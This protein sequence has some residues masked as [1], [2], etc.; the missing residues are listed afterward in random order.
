MWAVDSCQP[1]NSELS[2]MYCLCSWR[3]GRSP[4]EGNGNTLQCSHLEN[5]MDGGAWWATV[6]EVAKSWTIEQITL[7][8]HFFVFLLCLIC[9]E[10]FLNLL[11]WSYDFYPSFNYCCATHWLICGVELS[12]HPTNKFNFTMVYDPF[13]MLINSVC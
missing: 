1:Q 3:S 12:L 8:F 9:W 10:S 13:N 4:G 2:Q 7:S 6:H 5:S 11:V